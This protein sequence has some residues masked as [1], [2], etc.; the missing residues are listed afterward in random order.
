[1]NDP[2]ESVGT[3]EVVDLDAKEVAT[4]SPEARSIFSRS[5]GKPFSSKATKTDRAYGLV[6][7]DS[8]YKENFTLI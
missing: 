2:T 4:F 5:K 6:K 8:A 7:Y 3:R 1:L